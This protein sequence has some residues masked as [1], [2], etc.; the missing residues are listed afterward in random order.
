M[1]DEPM[2][3]KQCSSTGR[4]QIQVQDNLVVF[5]N[6]LNIFLSDPATLLRKTRFLYTWICVG[7]IL[8]FVSQI[9]VISPCLIIYAESHPYVW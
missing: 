9:T 7:K 8:S 1:V 4:E 3:T 2:A 6:I 5:V